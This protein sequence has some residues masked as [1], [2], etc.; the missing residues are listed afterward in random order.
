MKILLTE[1]RCSG[2]GICLDI[3]PQ[4]VYEIKAVSGRKFAIPK[5]EAQCSGCGACVTQCPQGAIAIDR[6]IY[7]VRPP[8]DYPPEEGHFLRGNDYSPVAVVVLLNSPYGEV[9]SEVEKMVRDS[10]ECGAALAGTLQ[11]ANMGIEK[12]VANVV[13]NPNIRYLVICG[14]EVEGHLPGEALKALIEHGLDKRG[15]RGTKAFRPYLLNIPIEAVERFRRQIKVVDLI[16]AVDLDTLRRVISACYQEAPIF[17][18]GY[19]L[20]DV[21]AYPERPMN[22]KIGWRITRLDILSEEEMDYL[23]NEEMRHQ[24]GGS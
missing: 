5:G 3:C 18:G 12:I 2:C 14:R 13:A 7:K 23:L 21:G 1:D 16:G 17:F 22:L 20:Y 15:I 4:K 9:P 10:I 8:D 19:E 11:T 6:G 24:G